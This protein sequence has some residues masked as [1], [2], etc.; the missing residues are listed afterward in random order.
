[1]PVKFGAS[2]GVALLPLLVCAQAD[3]QTGTQ[4]SVME[5]FAADPDVHV[6]WSSE[7]ARLENHDTRV[8]FTS[9]ILENNSRPARRISGVLVELSRGISR[10]RIYLDEE[11][12]ERT[13]RALEGIALALTRSNL[14]GA[15]CMGAPEFWPRY[16]WAWNK[17]HELN[18]EVCGYPGQQSLVL[19]PR[20]G[21]NSFTFPG[22]TPAEAAA[23]FEKAIQQY[24]QH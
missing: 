7:V 4:P 18:A 8:V 17:Y 6:A 2:F 10:D 11:A 9:L 22:E 19:S 16:G 24:K 20:S 5:A 13:R 23:I 14:P 1:M 15:G 12:S 21:Q 3:T